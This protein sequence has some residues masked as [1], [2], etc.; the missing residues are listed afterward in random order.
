MSVYLVTDQIG[1]ATYVIAESKDTA[2]IEAIQ[3]GWFDL[4]IKEI[5]E[6]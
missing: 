6:E 5:S 4:E 1:H 2:M 3:L